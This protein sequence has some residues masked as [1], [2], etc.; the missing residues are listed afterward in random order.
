[1]YFLTV[2]RGFSNNK[3]IDQHYFCHEN[4]FLMTFSELP[5]IVLSWYHTKMRCSIGTSQFDQILEQTF[6][7]LYE[8][9]LKL[10]FCAFTLI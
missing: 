5:P 8:S 6:A 7:V 2:Q 10:N 1:M 9:F 4:F 3:S